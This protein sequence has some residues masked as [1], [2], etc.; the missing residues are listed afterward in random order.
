MQCTH[1]L[2]FSHLATHSL[3]I[4]SESSALGKYNARFKREAI[5]LL[6]SVWL[7][8]TSIRLSLSCVINAQAVLMHIVLLHSKHCTV[9]FLHHQV[10]CV[11]SLQQWKL[12]ICHHNTSDQSFVTTL[13]GLMV[14][15]MTIFIRAARFLGGQI[16]HLW[17]TT[18]KR[19][20]E[21]LV[22]SPGIVKTSVKVEDITCKNEVIRNN[23]YILC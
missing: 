14:V 18:F 2:P 21:N 4:V 3:V 11:N 13:W 17:I 10:N 6:S 23:E 7:F 5:L 9:E 8:I 20:G 19:F 16:L 22:M 1:R 12:P 15:E